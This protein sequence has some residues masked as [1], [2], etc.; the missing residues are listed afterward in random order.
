VGLVAASRDALALDLAVA[1]LLGVPQRR[2][3]LYRAARRRGLLPQAV[4]LCGDPAEE[5]AVEG[6]LLPELDSLDLVP[7]AFRGL[8]Q[9]RLVSRPVQD[10]GACAGCGKC[11]EVCPARA[12]VLQKLRL[13]FDYDRCIRCY[14]CQEVCPARAIGF[15]SG[16]LV[17][18]LTRLGR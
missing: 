10:P 11:V 4:E 13:R 5:L 8:L 12:V 6:F 9:R 17:R 7:K 3:P 1:G 14:C 18:L 16:P 2:F 15:H